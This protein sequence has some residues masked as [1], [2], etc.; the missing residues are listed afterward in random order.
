[1]GIRGPEWR[2][3][4][5]LLLF[6]YDANLDNIKSLLSHQSLLTAWS[7]FLNLIFSFQWSQAH[8]R[9]LPGYKGIL[10]QLVAALPT[11][12]KRQTSLMHAV[13]LPCADFFSFWETR[14][15]TS[16]A[17]ACCNRDLSF[18]HSVAPP[19]S[20]V[21]SVLLNNSVQGGCAVTFRFISGLMHKVEY[22]TASIEPCLLSP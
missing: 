11:M 17:H 9:E 22:Y 6:N 12:T 16:P 18:W 20:T 5:F 3:L 21:V 15:R 10:R 8:A 19:H 14:L 2:H 7:G 13:P 1:M 4:H